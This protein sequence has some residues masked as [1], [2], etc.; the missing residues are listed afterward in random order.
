MLPGKQ[1]TT[2]YIQSAAKG[3]GVR[4]HQPDIGVVAASGVNRGIVAGGD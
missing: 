4:R 2:C 3:G 1:M